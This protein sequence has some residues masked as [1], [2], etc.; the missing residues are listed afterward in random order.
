MYGKRVVV[1]GN[2]LLSEILSEI[3]PVDFKVVKISNKNNDTKVPYYPND[4]SSGIMGQFLSDASLTNQ[5]HSTKKDVIFT[6]LSFENNL[7]CFRNALIEKYQSDSD[8][9]RELFSVISEIGMEWKKY[10]NNRFRKDPSIFKLSGK[11]GMI[12]MKNLD[13]IFRLPEEA[14]NLICSILPRND[15]TLAVFG[16]YLVTQ[17]FDI[18]CIENSLFEIISDH[19]KNEAIV[20]D[21]IYD[22]KQDFSEDDV[23]VDCRQMSKPEIKGG[24]AKII[25][26]SEEIPVNQMFFINSDSYWIHIWNSSI[27]E[28]DDKTW[29]VEYVMRGAD[30]DIQTIKKRIK[31]IWNVNVEFSEIIDD[32]KAEEIFGVSVIR[33]YNWAFNKSQTLKDPMNLMRAPKGNVLNCEKWGY[34]WFSAAYYV[35]SILAND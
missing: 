9:I 15:V 11:Y 17:A 13:S 23:I 34:A 26:L 6:E 12:E 1:I 19:K 22:L 27:I 35:R 29:N 25:G 8:Q 31:A 18:H 16:G 14:K 32:D 2:N 3:L 28:P 4:V 33:G 20:V 5:Y 24:Y 7:D 30:D 21:D 10:I